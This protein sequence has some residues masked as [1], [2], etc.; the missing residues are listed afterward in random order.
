MEMSG[1][2]TA[3]RWE[4]GLNHEKSPDFSPF[5]L[6]INVFRLATAARSH[7]FAVPFFFSSYERLEPRCL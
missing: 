1:K 7:R 2:S 4:N 5:S 6:K 3:M